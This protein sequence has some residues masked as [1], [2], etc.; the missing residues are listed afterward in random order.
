MRLEVLELSMTEAFD[1][2][3][4]ELSEQVGSTKTRCRLC[5]FGDHARRESSR[6]R[7]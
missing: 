1:E 2:G 3:L 5:Q 6:G 4:M 7:L